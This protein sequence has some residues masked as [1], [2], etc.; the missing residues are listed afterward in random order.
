MADVSPSVLRAGPFVVDLDRLRVTRGGTA[1]A[2]SGQP[3]QVLVA[4]VEARGR[5]VTREELMA[6][7]WPDAYRIDTGRRLNTAVRA[8][9]EALDDCAE[10]PVFVETVRGRGYRWIGKD[11]PAQSSALSGSGRFRAAAIAALAVVLT[12]SAQFIPQAPTAAD[13]ERLVGA[14]SLANT[15]PDVALAMLDR[16]VAARPRYEAAQVLR[17]E[18]AMKAWREQPSAE[19]LARVRASVLAARRAVG[20]SADLAVVEAELKWT[21]DWDWRGAERMY[22]LALAEAPGHVR[23]RTGLAW[24]LLNAGR[25]VEAFAQAAPLLTRADLDPASRAQ[26]G[27][28][29][30]RMGRND[31]AVRMCAG[32]DRHLNLLS[33]RHTAF[34]R[35]GD[36]EGA[37][38]AGLALMEQLHASRR[39]VRAVQTA[40]PRLGYQRFL[41]WRAAHLVTGDAQNFQ[42]AQLAADAGR[43]DE[44]MARLESAFAA[45]DP[46]LVKLRTTLEF[47]PLSRLPRY[48]EMLREIGP[49]R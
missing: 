15:A 2:L 1:I 45:R 7:L 3:L 9:R 13:R 31:L 42:R 46:A 19:R 26:L 20:Q 41:V 38:A 37:R 30:L 11:A 34:A 25:E 33:C 21:G 5:V 48:A 22:R 28:F 35:L 6:L 14:A 27:W 29:L 47:A 36:E 23:A 12:G 43:F 8:L 40:D 16:L 18:L 49:V 4:L 10:T 17:A 39:D 32:D 44:A 24:L